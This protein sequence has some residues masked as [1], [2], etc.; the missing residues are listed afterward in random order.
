MSERQLP[1]S[2]PRPDVPEAVRVQILATEHWSLLAARNLTYGAIYIRSNI[3]RTVVSAAATTFTCWRTSWRGRLR[4]II[5]I[6]EMHVL[7]EILSIPASA[8]F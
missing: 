3:F 4:P 8:D 7:I 6:G 1:P 5:S 2:S